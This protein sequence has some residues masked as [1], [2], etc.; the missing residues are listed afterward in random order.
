M[1]LRSRMNSIG[2]IGAGTVGTALA[3]SLSKQGY[4][5]TGVYS[6]SLSSSERLAGR[7]PG[8]RIHN[9]SQ[10][11]AD[12]SDFV[13]ITTPDDAIATVVTQTQWRQGQSVVHCSG[14]DSTAVLEPA[15]HAGAGTGCIHPL[16]TFA[17]ID[18]AIEN[19]PGS[20]FALEAK[21]PLLDVLKEMAARL[22]GHSVVLEAKDKVLYHASA[23]I[24]CNYLVTLVKMATELWETFGVS[25]PEA[26]RALAPLLRGT[27]NNMVNI[28]FPNCLTGPIARG[29]IGTVKKHMEALKQDREHPTIFYLY[30]ILG[31]QTIPIALEKGRIDA[32]RAKDLLAVLAPP[33]SP[34]AAAA[35]QSNLQTG[36]LQK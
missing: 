21:E 18:H 19:L 32:Q 8:C 23:V 29:D 4:P 16:Q 30:Q 3:A 15:H 27:L 13:F 12:R 6:R 22:G 26:T 25:S 24:A 2:F 5:V 33:D 9:S 14:A 17:G 28:G 35:R 1:F 11:L 10:E 7:V 20:T 36:G 34:A 31:M